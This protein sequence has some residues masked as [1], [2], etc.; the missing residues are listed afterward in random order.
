MRLTQY[1][2]SP[3][4]EQALN[5][6][7][8]VVPPTW[9]VAHRLDLYRSA[10]TAFDSDAPEAAKRE[11]FR[12]IYESLR[13]GWQVFRPKDSAECWGS[14]QIYAVLTNECQ[15]CAR[16]SSLTLA[17]LT[18]RESQANIEQCLRSLGR[19]KPTKH[20]PAVY[21][22]MAVAKF[23]HFFN[24]RLFPIYDTA[25]MWEKVAN[26]A[27]KTDYVEFCRR[28]GFQ[29]RED[30]ARFNLQYTLW[31]AETIRDADEGCMTTFAEWFASQVKGHRDTGDILADI[32][33]YYAAAFEMIAIGAAHL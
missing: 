4:T 31:A 21:P 3:R 27:F 32:K 22:W 11:S 13:S 1:F 2:T 17:T 30:T 25:F 28:R 10:K 8:A 5:R 18:E 6:Y 33:T 7:S 14:E 19:M 16:Q 29:P 12:H 26:G 9:S 20:Y 23:S 24:P 15:P